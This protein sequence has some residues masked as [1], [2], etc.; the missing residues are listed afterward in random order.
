LLSSWAGRV[1]EAGVPDFEKLIEVDSEGIWCFISYGVRLYGVK[2]AQC[3]NC[4]K[5][6]WFTSEGVSM[7]M[8]LKSIACE[9]WG[10]YS[11]QYELLFHH[12]CIVSTLCQLQWKILVHGQQIGMCCQQFNCQ[13][14]CSRVHRQFFFRSLLFRQEK[15]L[16]F[17]VVWKAERRNWP[18]SCDTFLGFEYVGTGGNLSRY[19]PGNRSR[20]SLCTVALLCLLGLWTT[21]FD[22]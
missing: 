21:E 2:C 16:K 6:T 17:F 3:K 22:S 11:G 19:A 7:A 9:I 5:I 18:V 10:F 13:S 12:F 1:S 4:D 8:L 20:T 15:E 14:A